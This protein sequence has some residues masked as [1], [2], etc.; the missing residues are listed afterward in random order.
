MIFSLFISQSL[1]CASAI[2]ISG[3]I[4]KRLY[5]AADGIKLLSFLKIIMLIDANAAKNETRLK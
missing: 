1:F 2:L 4:D 5:L 3:T